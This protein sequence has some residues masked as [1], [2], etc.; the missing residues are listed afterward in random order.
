MFS[1]PAPINEQATASELKNRLDWG[2]PALSIIDIRSRA[3]FNANRITGAVSIPAEELMER[4]SK[5]LEFER[6]IY[7]YGASDEQAAEATTQ[8]RGAGYKSVAVLKGGFEAW[9]SARGAVE[10]AF[11]AA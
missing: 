6:D 1:I 10:G 5:T 2:E 11:V 4:V 7:I 3:A 8:L 9:K